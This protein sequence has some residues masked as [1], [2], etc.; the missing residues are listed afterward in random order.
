MSEAI[1]KTLRSLG[2]GIAGA[3]LAQAAV[4]LT[5]HSADFGTAAVW[6]VPL[7]SSLVDLLRRQLPVES[8]N[9]AK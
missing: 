1:Q 8:I 6:V 2:I 7:L 5:G 9:P 3:A 4:W